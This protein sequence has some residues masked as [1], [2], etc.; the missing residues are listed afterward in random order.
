VSALVV[1]GIGVALPAVDKPMDALA[2]P[3]AEAWPGWFDVS[4]VLPGRGYKRLPDACQYLLAA[5]A[6][7]LAD[8]GDA[9]SATRPD[10]R[11]VVVGT[12][13]AAVSLMDQ[14][15]RTIIDCGA[16]ELS[17]LTAP[18]FSPSL[19]ASRLAL[20]HTVNG[21]TLT[22]NS[23][24]TG[25]VDAL[26][27][28]ARALGCGRAEMVL[29]G[30]TEAALPDSEPCHAD[31]DVGAVV[32]ICQ[33]PKTQC[34]PAYG[35]VTVR[36]ASLA[37]HASASQLDELWN[38]LCP[39]ATTPPPVDAVLD[40]SAIGSATWAWLSTKTP[41][42]TVL[43]AG[44]GCLSALRRVAGLLATGVRDHLV[45]TAAAE[46]GVAFARL[47]GPENDYPCLNGV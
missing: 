11:G 35:T 25:G 4:A 30:A 40:D 18:Y 33:L 13:N 27:V 38:E 2:T 28:G 8:A 3:A 14:Q 22:V 6:A 5:A 7:A 16:D 39:G 26:R 20:E 41:R 44:A 21:F 17:P 19:F 46:G 45:V 15:D 24:R 43:P 1:T 12:N 29:A 37:Q 34:G 31:S 32:M 36:S 42:L 9:F 10:R 23:P 47:T